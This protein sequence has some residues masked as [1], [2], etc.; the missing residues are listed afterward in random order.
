MSLHTL[1][2][3]VCVISTTFNGLLLSTATRNISRHCWVRK[4]LYGNGGI[5]LVDSSSLL[6]LS[7][8]LFDC[9]SGPVE[10]SHHIPS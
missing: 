1:L 10:D 6:T 8:C 9:L 2:S 3:E 5:Q 7:P 4:K